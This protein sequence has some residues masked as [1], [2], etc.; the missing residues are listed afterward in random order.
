MSCIITYQK[1]NGDIIYKPRTSIYGRRI[2]DITS[3]GWKVIDIHYKYEGNYYMYEDY[4]KLIRKKQ[5]IKKKFLRKLA[6]GINKMA[7]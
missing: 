4:M 5:S 3:M 6:K 2:G 1:Q 7:R